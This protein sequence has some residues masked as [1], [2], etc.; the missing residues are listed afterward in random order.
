MSTK[1]YN[2]SKIGSL[3]I[4]LMILIVF[5]FQSTSSRDLK[6]ALTEDTL[7]QRA[8]EEAQ[9]AG[10]QNTSFRE[11]TTYQTAY[12]T[13]GEWVKLIGGQLEAGAASVG[14][15]P[16]RGIFLLSVDG[17]VASEDAKNGT[18][19]NFIVGI[20]TDT[21]ES[22]YSTI[23]PAGSVLPLPATTRSN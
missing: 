15:I 17:V 13:L 22:A 12:T 14:L 3:F 6:A 18:T 21:G 16:E 19:V 9:I 4:V 5:I 7:I 8:F 1:I 2:R 11:I 20:Y 10:L 23:K